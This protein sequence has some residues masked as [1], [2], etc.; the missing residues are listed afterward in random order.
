MKNIKFIRVSRDITQLRVQ[1]ETGISQSTISKYETGESI[2]TVENLLLLADFYNTSLDYLMD[3]TDA[4][5]PYPKKSSSP[6]YH[7]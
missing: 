7:E 1:M 5:T 3:R 4:V 2:P 6:G